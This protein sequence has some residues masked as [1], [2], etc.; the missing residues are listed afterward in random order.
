LL[1]ML[2]LPV[3]P[4]LLLLLLLVRLLWLLL[5]LLLLMASVACSFSPDLWPACVA[6]HWDLN[7]L[8]IRL[9]AG[10]PV[11]TCFYQLLHIPDHHRHEALLLLL[12]CCH[13]RSFQRCCMGSSA[14]KA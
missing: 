5:L 1:L 13:S 11:V 6:V 10:L 4:L 14:E 12:H 7:G 3:L 8:H 2:L 9:C